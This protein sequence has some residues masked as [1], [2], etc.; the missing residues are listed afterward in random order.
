[1]NS[2]TPRR[3]AA[4]VPGDASNAHLSRRS[5]AFTSTGLLSILLVALLGQNTAHAADET[6]IWER[7]HPQGGKPYDQLQ[8]QTLTVQW[9]GSDGRE[10][11]L[12]EFEDEA[13]YKNCDFSRAYLLVAPQVTG[14]FVISREDNLL[15]G[16]RWFGSDILDDCRNGRMKFSVKVRPLLQDKFAGYECE[17]NFEAKDVVVKNAPDIKTCRKICKRRRGCVSVMYLGG[18]KGKCRLYNKAPFRAVAVS[19]YM[20]CVLYFLFFPVHYRNPVPV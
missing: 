19:A 2:A 20:L 8:C 10:H 13:A 4:T 1:M 5:S 17:G 11:S 12:Y 6:V 18:N 7:N 15:P 9:T 16:K 3:R 14:T